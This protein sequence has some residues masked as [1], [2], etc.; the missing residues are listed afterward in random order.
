MTRQT[1]SPLPPVIAVLS[2]ILVPADSCYRVIALLEKFSE[3]PARK[4]GDN[5]DNTITLF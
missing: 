2:P 5:G 4:T 1:L 3:R